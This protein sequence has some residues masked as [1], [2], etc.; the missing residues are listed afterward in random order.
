MM[1]RRCPGESEYPTGKDCGDNLVLNIS[2]P[3]SSAGA[4]WVVLMCILTSAGVGSS[5]LA[6]DLSGKVVF[7]R[8]AVAPGNG[9]P[10]NF[11]LNNCATQR[12]LDEEGRQQAKQIG[13]KLRGRKVEFA[14]IYSSEWCRCRETA[15]LLDMGNVT[16]LRALNS[17][18]EHHFSRDQLLPVLEEMLFDVE[19]GDVPILMVTHFVTIAAVTG[20]SVS[21]GDLVVYDPENGESFL[22]YP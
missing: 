14:V 2:K 10:N 21:S 12:N 7:M 11:D 18:Y 16:P 20:R 5:A 8:H 13:E 3:N 17:F 22:L 1:E 9:D 4:A 19:S 6:E 15:K